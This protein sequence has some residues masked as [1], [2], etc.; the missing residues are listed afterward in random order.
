MS[1]LM[2]KL[3]YETDLADIATSM[4]EFARFRLERRSVEANYINLTTTAVAQDRYDVITAIDTLAH[5]P[6]VEETANTLHAALKPGGLLV[7]N[8]DV[9]QQSP[10]TAWH[11]YDD[12]TNLRWRVHRAGF[13]PVQRIGGKAVY[14]YRRVEPRGLGRHTRSLRDLVLLRSPLRPAYRALRW[15]ARQLLRQG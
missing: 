3:G 1:Q 15:N 9:R 7:A 11:L 6:D 10:A 14:V 12:D 2:S 8:F 13:E 5:V 4:L